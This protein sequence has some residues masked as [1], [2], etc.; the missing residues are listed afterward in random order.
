MKIKICGLTSPEEAEYVNKNHVDFAGMVLF[1]PKSKRNISLSQAKNICN[2]L[3]REIRTVAVTV[4]PTLEQAKQ[5]Q[6]AGFD[7]I[8]IHG[9]LPEGLFEAVKIPVL[10]AFNISDMD[11]Y[12]SYHECTGIAG[13]VFDAQEPGSGKV[14]DW[15]LVADIPGDDK[16]LLLAGG[17]NPD[18]VQEAMRYV[19]P[20][21]VDVSSGVEYEER[22]GKDPQKI[23]AFVK[24][25]RG[26]MGC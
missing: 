16:M 22:Q 24:A 4:A 10:K 8:Q 26:Q 15:S 5:I 23:D 18:N 7:Y 20:D 19:K 6:E 13:Y 17:L 2:A 1:Y 11:M 25:V 21:G 3:D 9:S 14:F 12:E